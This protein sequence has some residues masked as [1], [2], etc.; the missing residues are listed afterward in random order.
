MDINRIRIFCEV[1]RQNSFSAAARGLKLTQSAVSQQVKVLEREL[2]MHLFDEVHRS[3]PTAAGDY[4]FR[5]GTLIL[6]A[7]EDLRRG[8]GQATGVGSGQLRFG[9]IDVA[10][11]EFMPKVL[12]RFRKTHPQIKVEA[13]VKTSGELMTMVENHE[14]DLAVGVTNRLSEGLRSRTIY[15]DSIVAVVPA[16]SPLK[17]RSISIE[18]LRG[19]PLI[20]YPLSSYSRM[21]IEEIFRRGGV[22]PAV[23]M[24]MHY[25]AAI[26]SLVQQGMGTGLISELSAEESRLKGQAIV[27][28][29]ELRDARTIGVVTHARRRLTPQAKALAEAIAEAV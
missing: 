11:I 9:M 29:R 1:Y 18:D 16:A 7:M 23:N 3:Q 12:S 6:A 21:L 2:G 8:I 10:A 26:C 17:K 25:P 4:L 22:I 13:V 27:P 5:E 14:L 28:V 24:E 20:L 19:E 15:R